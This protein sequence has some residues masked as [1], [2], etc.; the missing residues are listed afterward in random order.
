MDAETN[1]NKYWME[2]AKQWLPL[3]KED[4][5]ILDP[6]KKLPVFATAEI[7]LE[8]LLI[9]K[10]T[11]HKPADYY[12]NN[13]IHTPNECVLNRYLIPCFRHYA[14]QYKNY[15]KYVEYLKQFIP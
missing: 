3:L 2:F 13:I 14:Y 1:K 4:L 12:N 8:S 7:V 15:P 6:K 5:D 10:T 9:D 11:K